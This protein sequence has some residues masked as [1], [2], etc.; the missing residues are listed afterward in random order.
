[1]S[2]PGA[3]D[4]DGTEHAAEEDRSAT[5]KE[6]VQGVSEPAPYDG[7]ANVRSKQGHIGLESSILY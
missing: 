7:R 4:R 5:A 3:D 2:E 1:M 6:V